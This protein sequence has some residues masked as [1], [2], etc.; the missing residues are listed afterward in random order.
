MT[1]KFGAITSSTNPEEISNRIK[2]ITL[3][4]SSIIIFLLGHYFN[5]VLTPDDMI[6]V[7][8]QVGAVGGAIWTVYGAGMAVWSYFFKKV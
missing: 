3:A 1:Q 5:I 8:S 7:A 4:A 2:G 6:A